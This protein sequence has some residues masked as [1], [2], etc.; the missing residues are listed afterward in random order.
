MKK[1]STKKEVK[2][3]PIEELIA[4]KIQARAQF[5]GRGFGGNAQNTGNKTFGAQL[6][7]GSRGDR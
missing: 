3:T 6:K 4:K 2:K 7:K 1:E 5:Q